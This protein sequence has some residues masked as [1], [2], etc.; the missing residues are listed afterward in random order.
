MVLEPTIAPYTT[1]NPSFLYSFA[2]TPDNLARNPNSQAIRRYSKKLPRVCANLL[3]PEPLPAHHP[4]PM[5]SAG[6]LNEETFR[7]CTK[8]HQGKNRAD[9]P[10]CLWRTPAPLARPRFRGTQRPARASARTGT[11][12]HRAVDSRTHPRTQPHQRRLGRKNR[13]GPK[14][15]SEARHAGQPL[16]PG[17]QGRL[18]F[19]SPHQRTSKSFREDARPSLASSLL[20]NSR[21]YRAP[22]K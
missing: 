16:A 17:S 11:A 18:L 8:T 12:R 4:P 6:L 5:R 13:H 3:V 14:R 15:R 10:N 7:L 21:K 22:S 19:A 2:L 1:A 9:F 20:R